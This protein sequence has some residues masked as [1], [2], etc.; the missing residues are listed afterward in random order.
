MLCI[1]SFL[2]IE[3][4]GLE[5]H[6]P[7]K[8]FRNWPYHYDMPPQ[9]ISISSTLA[10]VACEPVNVSVT[11]DVPSLSDSNC[12][13]PFAPMAVSE[14]PLDVITRFSHSSPSS[15]ISASTRPTTSPT[16]RPLAVSSVVSSDIEEG[17]GLRFNVAGSPGSEP[18]ASP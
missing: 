4:S 3:G 15:S 10:V 12:N 14:E 7:Q 5:S 11:P 13:S 17:P 8:L 2:K 9:S 18:R 1:Y 16:S 6:H